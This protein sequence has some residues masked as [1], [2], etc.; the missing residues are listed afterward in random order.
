MYIYAASKAG[1]IIF[2]KYNWAFNLRFLNLDSRLK[3]VGYF[4]P[5]TYDTPLSILVKASIIL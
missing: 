4:S 2:K 3:N 5:T 1:S